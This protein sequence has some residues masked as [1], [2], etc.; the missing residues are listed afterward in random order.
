MDDE[1]DQLFRQL[2][3]SS[4]S[5]IRDEIDSKPSKLR[6]AI[7]ARLTRF[8]R[9]GHSDR[10]VRSGAARGLVALFSELREEVKMMLDSR[11]IDHWY[12]IHFTMFSAF[13]RE[14]MPNSVQKEVEDLLADYVKQA[15]TESGFAAWKAAD[16]LG[17]EWYTPHTADLLRDSLAKAKYVAGRSAAIHGLA[18]ALNHGTKQLR[19][20]SLEALRQSAR[21]DRS[22][23]VRAKA[24]YVLDSGGCLK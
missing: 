22:A 14:E 19:S 8:A 20:A 2:R 6:G 7:R 21:R 15:V 13:E 11:D 16:V 1:I 4:V 9:Q 12:D 17:D 24:K 23:V 10:E 3:Q 18:H 5:V